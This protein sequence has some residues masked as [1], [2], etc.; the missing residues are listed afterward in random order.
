[1]RVHRECSVVNPHLPML[2]DS[3]L[4]IEGVQQYQIS[5][6]RVVEMMWMKKFRGFS[7][8]AMYHSM[9]SPYWHEMVQAIN[10]SPKGYKIPIFDRK[11][12]KIH[13]ALRKITNA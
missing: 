7:M 12:T 9:F 5:L 3:Y 8:H 11:R 1:M 4:C 6:T 10:G 13:G 2:A